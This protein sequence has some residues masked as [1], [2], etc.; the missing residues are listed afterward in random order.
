[1]IGVNA[2]LEKRKHLLFFNQS[3]GVSGPTSSSCPPNTVHIFS[4]VHRGIVADDVRD[5]TDIYTSGY[6]IRAY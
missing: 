3:P 5:M 2:K 6:K 4:H 1:M